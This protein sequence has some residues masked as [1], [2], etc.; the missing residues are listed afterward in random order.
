MLYSDSEDRFFIDLDEL[1]DFYLEELEEGYIT[2]IEDLQIRIC[3]PSTPHYFSLEE[4]LEDILP[5]EFYQL[6][7]DFGA[8]EK[9]VNDYLSS[10]TFSWEPGPQALDPSWLPPYEASGA[11]ED[12]ADKKYISPFDG[13]TK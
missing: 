3:R 4:H 5:E 6:P 10:H 7:G 13:E 9:V 8:V 2:D 11:S 1:Y 12:S